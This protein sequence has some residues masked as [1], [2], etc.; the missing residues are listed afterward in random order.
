MSATVKNSSASPSADA[1]L[2]RLARLAGHWEGVERLAPSPWAP[3]GTGRAALELRVGVAGT[4]LLQDYRGRS[5]AD[6]REVVGHGVFT[7]DRDSGEVVWSWVD[8]LGFAAPAPSRGHWS[9]DALVL[10]RTSP[11]GTNRT[12]FELDGEGRLHQRTAVRFEGDERFN[13]LISA[14]YERVGGAAAASAEDP[15]YGSCACGA[16]RFRLTA[17]PSGAATVARA[18]VDLVKGAELLG[19]YRPAE[20]EAN[21]FC[22]Q[23]GASVFGAGWPDGPDVAIRPDALERAPERP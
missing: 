5:D 7:V 10:E 18:A 17:P 4:A 11:R 8:D 21:A 19:A 16:V 14:T 1:P 3:G 23:C 13:E 20:G 6:G 2:G 15:A 22:L 9:H 12:T